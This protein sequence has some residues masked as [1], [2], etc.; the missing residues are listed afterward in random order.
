MKLK[1]KIQLL[2]TSVI[3]VVLLLVNTAIFF[4]FYRISIDAEIDRIKA[5][6]RVMME[7]LSANT[8]VNPSELLKA[9]IPS[10]GMARVINAH[11]ETLQ[12]VTKEIEFY[13]LPIVYVNRETNEVIVGNDGIRYA[14][15]SIPLIWENGEVV[16]LQVTEKLVGI[17]ETM[18]TLIYVLLFSSLIMVI[19]IV[20]GGGIISRLLIK[21]IQALTNTMTENYKQRSWKKID[22]PSNSKDELSQMGTVYN[23]MIDRLR[24]NFEKQ[25]EFVSDA[26]HELKTPISIIKSYSHLLDRW[27]KEKEEVYEESIHAIRSETEKMEH[28]VGQLLALA[29]NQQKENLQFASIDVVSLVQEVIRLF[30]VTYN[31][32]IILFTDFHHLQLSCDREKINQVLYI[33]LDNACKYSHDEVHI[34]LNK[35]QHEIEISIQDF[36]EGL[37]D[38]ERSRIFDRFYRVDKA[39]SRE[40]GGT[41]LGLTIAQHIVDAHGGK[42]LVNSEEGHGSTF[43]I[44]LPY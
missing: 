35:S 38:T 5:E 3:L 21:P 14:I 19:P 23:H 27:G 41:G 18:N 8:E 13:S 37:T 26:S 30:T 7:A 33:L 29:K 22:L 10:N 1:T 44:Y 17:H 12:V 31:R 25:E 4:L 2:L 16:T 28:L 24:E 6:T 15:I 9:Y 42:I 36:G 20:I 40:T 34:Y 11:R 43:S 32:K 39:R